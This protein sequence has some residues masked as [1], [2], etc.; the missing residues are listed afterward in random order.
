M[1]KT[2]SLPLEPQIVY[3]IPFI[4]A[5]SDPNLSTKTKIASLNTKRSERVSKEDNVTALKTKM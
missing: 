4:V 2:Y 5:A 3:V 1:R